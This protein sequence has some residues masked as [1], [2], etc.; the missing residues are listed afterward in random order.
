ML[1]KRCAEVVGEGHEDRGERF[2]GGNFRNT[3]E[4]IF[5]PN[6][7]VLGGGLSEE[8]IAKGV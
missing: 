5:G 2:E 4:A 8:E 6:E 7:R 1:A 3:Q